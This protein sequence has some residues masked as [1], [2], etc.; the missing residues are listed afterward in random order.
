MDDYDTDDTYGDE[1][2]QSSIAAPLLR[3]LLFA[4]LAFGIYALLFGDLGGDEDLVESETDEPVA[5]IT[6]EESVPP[7]TVEE[8][9]TGDPNEPGTSLTPGVPSDSSEGPGAAPAGDIVP[10]TTVQVIAGANTSAAQVDA[11]VQVLGQ[12][13]YAV[14]EDGVSGNPYPQTTVFPT[15]GQEAAA[16]ALV[17]SDPRFAVVGENPGNL[18]D[19]LQIHVLVGEDF[20]V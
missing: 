10:G 18:T 8:F 14:T 15:A 6:V 5:D 19:Q 1:P 4:A 9:P 20:P 12:L 16:Q 3:A 2:P 11:A 13:G 7:P 17:A